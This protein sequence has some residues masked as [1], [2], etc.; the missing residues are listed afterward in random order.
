MKTIL[1]PTDFSAAADNAVEYAIKLAAQSGANIVLMNVYHLPMP[2]GEM[3]LALVSPQEIISHSDARIRELETIVEV[4]S[5]GKFKVQ[6]LVKQGFAAEEI[7]EAASAVNADL[8]V[9]GI[10]GTNSALGAAIGS[11][12]TAVIKHSKTPVLSIPDSVVYKP[13]KYIAFAFDYNNEPGD[14]VTDQLK[15]YAE[16]FD[17]TIQVINVVGSEEVPSLQMASAGVK[18]DDKLASTNH[19]LH[20]AEGTDVVQ[21]L[22]K[23]IQTSHSDWLVMIPHEYS[24]LKG[25]FHR[26]S[27]KQAAFNIDTPLLTIHD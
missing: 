7:V 19:N 26:S 9:M 17:A 4:K 16:F 23:F 1:V 3:P 6:T 25:L 21:E 20:Y 22:K 14:R 8:I 18:M 24:F 10:K 27:T 15:Y 12:T 11:V 2:A 5:T 13:V